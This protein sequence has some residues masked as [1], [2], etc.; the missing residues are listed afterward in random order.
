MGER[1]KLA[2][3]LEVV[4][5]SWCVG[6]AVRQ[7]PD[8]GA[9]KPEGDESSQRQLIKSSTNSFHT[10]RSIAACRSWISII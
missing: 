5:S 8:L 9:A 1:R 10:F 4:R 2:H 6:G 7:R 3:R